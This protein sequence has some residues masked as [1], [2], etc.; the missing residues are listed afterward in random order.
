MNDIKPN[1]GKYGTKLLFCPLLEER[2]TVLDDTTIDW[3]NQ[4]LDKQY[5]HHLRK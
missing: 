4:V 3:F 5:H 2:A 1:V